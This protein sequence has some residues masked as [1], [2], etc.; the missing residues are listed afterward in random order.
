MSVSW[1]LSRLLC[2]P[3][4]LAVFYDRGFLFRSTFLLRSER[5]VTSIPLRRLCDSLTHVSNFKVNTQPRPAEWPHPE[6]LEYA[7]GCIGLFACQRGLRLLILVTAAHPH[8]TVRVLSDATSG[9]NPERSQRAGS[10]KIG[11]RC[12]TALWNVR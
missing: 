9:S 11:W 4:S 2:D 1:N 5:F 7:P 8:Q 6:R 12:I 3:A 10:W